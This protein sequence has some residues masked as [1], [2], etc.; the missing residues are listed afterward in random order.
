MGISFSPV[1][2][3]HDVGSTF[4]LELGVDFARG[5]SSDV[6]RQILGLKNHPFSVFGACSHRSSPQS[7]T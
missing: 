2:I 6:H 5:F 4:H 7:V 3:A 1:L